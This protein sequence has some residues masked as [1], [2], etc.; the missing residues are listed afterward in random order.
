MNILIQHYIILNI[1]AL[2]SKCNSSVINAFIF[3]MCFLIVCLI[4]IFK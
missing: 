3:S 2:G 1:Y 4:L